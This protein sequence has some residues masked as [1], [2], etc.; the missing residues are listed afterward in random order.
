VSYNLNFNNYDRYGNMTCVQNSNTNGPCP[1]WSY[2]P[3]TNQLSSSTGCT[4]DA[5]GNLTKDCST[6]S[7]HTYQWD[8]EGR[9]G[10]VDSGPTWG[11]T[12]NAVG[13]RAQWAYTGG[14]DQHIFDPAGTSLGVYGAW[15][16]V[17]LGDRVLAVYEGSDTYFF[18]VNNLSSAEMLTNHAGTAVEDIP[19]YPWGQN[20][21][22]LWGSGGYDFAGM[23]YY[24]TKTSTNPTMFRF[25]SQNQGRWLSPDP[26]GGDLTNPQSLNRYAYV[27]NNPTSLIDPLGLDPGQ[28][29]D[30]GECDCNDPNCV[31]AECGGPG[32]PPGFWPPNGGAGSGGSGG[33]GPTVTLPTGNAGFPQSGLP[34]TWQLPWP[35]GGILPC[36]L[37][38]CGP[39]WN[40]WTAQVGGSFNLNLWFVSFNFVGGFAID[41]KGHLASYTAKGLGPATGGSGSIGVQGAISNAATV[42]DLGGPFGNVSGTFGAG[43]SVSA[44]VF[45][46]NSPNGPV[47]GGG[48]TA[49]AGVGGSGSVSVTKTTVTPL[50]SVPCQ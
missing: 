11:F 18:H 36:D 48:I 26:L 1:Q 44:D 27:L 9:V 14:A 15:D 37:V 7:N 12:Y 42:C 10:S 17:W 4:Y 46:G 41:S 39:I 50:G 8:A 43:G 24:D 28:G 45:Y 25:Y 35:S 3:G 34:A 30:P 33:G 22:K 31:N 47:K 40:P 49:G 23:P 29:S 20:T 21:W 13:D 5:A 19:F 32:W 16:V 6:A 2:T 38:V